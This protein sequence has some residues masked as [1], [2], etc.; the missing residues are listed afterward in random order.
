MNIS[1]QDL[2]LMFH[3]IKPNLT[4][5]HLN[6]N[7]KHMERNRKLSRAEPKSDEQVI[8]NYVNHFHILNLFRKK[9]Q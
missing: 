7:E 5:Q 4:T 1:P 9:V 6:N 2:I 8:I 3:T